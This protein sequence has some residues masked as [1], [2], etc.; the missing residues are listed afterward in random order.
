VTPVI[1]QDGAWRRQVVES[2]P[3]LD[4][5]ELYV[6]TLYQF[7]DPYAH[8]CNPRYSGGKDWEDHSF[9][10]DQA[11]S[12]WDLISTSCWAQWYML[13]IPATREAQIGGS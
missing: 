13:V 12:S 3:F 9:R 7:I 1:H 4:F 8:A 10:P 5:W 6:W 2:G 11:K